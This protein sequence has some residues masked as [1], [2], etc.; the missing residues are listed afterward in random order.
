MKST[1]KE[2]PEKLDINQNLSP[3]NVMIMVEKKKQLRN[4]DITVK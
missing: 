4:K 2:T 1:E 3:L